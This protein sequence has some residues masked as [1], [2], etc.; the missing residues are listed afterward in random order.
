MESDNKIYIMEVPQNKTLMIS[1]EFAM[2]KVVLPIFESSFKTFKEFVEMDGPNINEFT[3]KFVL[4]Y[5][6][7]CTEYIHIKNIY[8]FFML[9]YGISY[10]A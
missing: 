2:N 7:T 5:H 6:Y 8:T 10:L 4:E 9:A 3:G 1:K